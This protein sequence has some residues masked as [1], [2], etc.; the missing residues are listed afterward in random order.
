MA[1][2]NK[3]WKRGDR[4]AITYLNRTV[5]GRIEVASESGTTLMVAFEALLGAFAG[6]MPVAWNESAGEFRD[7]IL[8]A[9]VMLAE[10]DS[11]EGRLH[12]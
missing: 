10:G 1:G 3:I 7:I 12:A 4:V 5:T 8:G 6:H 9:P 2:P 11:K